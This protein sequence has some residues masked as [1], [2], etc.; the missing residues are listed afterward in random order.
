MVE[1]ISHFYHKSLYTKLDFK[2]T[3]LKTQTVDMKRSLLKYILKFA[4]NVQLLNTVQN[5]SN[6]QVSQNIWLRLSGLKWFIT[7]FGSM[8]VRAIL[9]LLLYGVFALTVDAL[10]TPL[11]FYTKFVPLSPAGQIYGNTY[12]D[13]TSRMGQVFSISNLFFK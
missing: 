7:I 10:S 3:F 4:A 13:E 8:Y 6:K 11:N 5:T 12:H 9:R 1:L 2:L